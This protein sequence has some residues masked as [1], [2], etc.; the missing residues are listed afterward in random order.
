MIIIATQ[1]HSGP[2]NN[3]V[4]KFDELN[5]IGQMQSGSSHGTASDMCSIVTAGYG[6]CSVATTLKTMGNRRAVFLF[7]RTSLLSISEPE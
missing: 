5:P 7:I 4:V 3:P 6:F 2:E 1:L